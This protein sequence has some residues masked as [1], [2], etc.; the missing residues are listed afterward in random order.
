MVNIAEPEVDQPKI[1][2]DQ[3]REEWVQ[4]IVEGNPGPFRE[5]SPLRGETSDGVAERK[6]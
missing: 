5:G 6:R 3:F 4:E 2:F 1:T